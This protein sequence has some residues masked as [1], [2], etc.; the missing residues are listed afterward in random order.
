MSNDNETSVEKTADGS[1]KSSKMIWRVIFTAAILVVLG[2]AAYNFTNAD[3]A[4]KPQQQAGDQALPVE[5]ITITPHD[6]PYT[7]RFLAQT[8]ASKTVQI[9]ARVNGFLIEQGFQEGETVEQGKLLFRIDPEPFQVALDQA[10]AGMQS[11][12]ANQKRANQQVKRFENLAQLQ[13]AATNEL[14]QAQEA[15][16]VAAAA[17]KSSEAMVERAKLDL[18]YATI[19]SP[20]TGLIGERLQDVGSYVGPGADPMLAVV[21][22]IDPLDVRFNISEKDILTWQRMSEADKV[23]NIPMEDVSVKV[24]L[25][26]GR[27]FPHIGTIDYVDVAVDPTTA[28]AVVRARVP[29]PENNLRPGQFVNVEIGGN[30]RIK[31]ITVPQVSVMQAPA[32]AS[33]Y[34]MNDKGIVT[35]RTVELGEWLGTEWIITSGLNEGDKVIA[36]NLMQI[37]PGMPVTAAGPKPTEKAKPETAPSNQ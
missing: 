8:E 34:V 28:S 37:R 17:V 21:R 1:E 7:A 20:I 13:Q 18:E 6:V 10:N 16:A 22:T 11:A 32:G 14:E 2:W 23:T 24:I 33:V 30:E 26:D 4:P 25:P 29:N 35:P 3:H 31:V 9:R 12:V 27:E 5:I 19:H 36:S 15:Q